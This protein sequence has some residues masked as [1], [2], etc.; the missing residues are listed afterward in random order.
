MKKLFI[1]ALLGVG[2]S[3]SA[4]TVV[5][6]DSKGNYVDVKVDTVKTPSFKAT[7][8]TFTDSKGVVYPV[9]VSK[10]GNLFYIKTAKTSGKKYNVYLKP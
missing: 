1:I 3:S 8:K 10:N 7:G 9:Y 5:K 6:T 2:I 4:Q